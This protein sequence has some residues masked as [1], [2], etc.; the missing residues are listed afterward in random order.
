MNASKLK[1]NK[2]VPYF[3]GHSRHIALG[4]REKED[5]QNTVRLA[6]WIH[7]PDRRVW[8]DDTLLKPFSTPGTASLC[9]QTYVYKNCMC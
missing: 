7:G 5:V 9:V 1:V 6:K 2:E 8:A 3:P 4:T